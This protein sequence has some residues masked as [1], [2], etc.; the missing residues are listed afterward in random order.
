MCHNVPSKKKK[1]KYRKK[2]E[3]TYSLNDRETLAELCMYVACIFQWCLRHICE[4]GWTWEGRVSAENR[5]CSRAAAVGKG[6]P[7]PASQGQGTVLVTAWL[8]SC[9]PDLTTSISLLEHPFSRAVAELQ[10]SARS[11]PQPGA[12]LCP[13]CCLSCFLR[14]ERMSPAQAEW[15]ASAGDSIW[16]PF[17]MAPLGGKGS[18]LQDVI[19]GESN[20]FPGLTEIENDRLTA[21]D[22]LL[23]LAPPS[24]INDW[25]RLKGSAA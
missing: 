14:T 13:V 17:A 16:Q 20:G 2:Q 10:P 21:C 22:E 19:W 6:H 25:W 5:K 4:T 18:L 7:W 9:A 24:W 3:K 8:C 11:P 12:S 1:K 15:L 23:I